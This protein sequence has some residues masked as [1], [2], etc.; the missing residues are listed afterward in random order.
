MGWYKVVNKL[1][2]RMNGLCYKK[3]K[4]KK[5]MNGWFLNKIYMHDAS[6]MYTYKRN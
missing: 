1:L 3:R 2:V 5:R 4:E 6:L